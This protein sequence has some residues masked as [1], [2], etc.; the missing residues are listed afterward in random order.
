MRMSTQ[1]VQEELTAT[2]DWIKKECDGVHPLSLGSST[3]ATILER[4]EGRLRMLIKDL[5]ADDP[6]YQEYYP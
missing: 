3:L 2:I 5:D 6:Q 1:D 4:V